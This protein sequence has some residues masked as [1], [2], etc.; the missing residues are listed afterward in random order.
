MNVRYMQ[1][2]NQMLVVVDILHQPVKIAQVEM[3]LHGAMEIVNG[4]HY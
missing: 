1:A 2:Q 4:I 3:V